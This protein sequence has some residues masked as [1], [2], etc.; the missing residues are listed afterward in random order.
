MRGKDPARM[1]P[2]EILAEVQA[3]LEADKPG[4][5]DY[6]T[7]VGQGEPLLS[8]SLGRLIR[9]VKALTDIPLAVITNGSLLLM[10][11]PMCMRWAVHR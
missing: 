4:E 8:A 9:D 7:F 11:S 2:E 3:K 6:I 10:P 5:I 1:T